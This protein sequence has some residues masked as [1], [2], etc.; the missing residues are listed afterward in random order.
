[1]GA[2]ANPEVGK[3]VNEYFVSAFQKVATFRIVGAAKQGGNVASYFCA[4]DGRVLHVVAGP[5]DAGTF[6]REA[7]WVVDNAKKAIAES[8]GDGAKF[9]TAMRKAH[10]EKLRQEFGVVVEAVTFD[11]PDPQ[12]PNSALTYNDPT[13][14]PLAPKLPPPPIDGPDVA[15]KAKQD[16]AANM[17]GNRA[18]LDKKGGRVWLNNVGVTHQLM[19]AHSMVKIEKVYGTIF[20]NILGEKISTAPVQVVK[21]FSWVQEGRAPRN[22]G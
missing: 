18:L 21:P 9:K 10:A 6:L 13:G 19:A 1:M 8:K 16:A 20:E 4:P 12:D 11:P 3:Y 2:L 17:P 14:R 22:G 5:V 15:L 7:K